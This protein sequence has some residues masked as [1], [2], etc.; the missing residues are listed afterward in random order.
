MIQRRGL[1]EHAVD[2]QQHLHRLLAGVDVDVRGALLDRFGDQRVHQLDHRRVLV[3]LVGQQ[4]RLGLVVRLGDGLDRLLDAGE[5][6]DQDVQVLDRGGR[7]AHATPG[8]HRDVVDRQHVGGV[9]HR[10]DHGAVLQKADRDRLVAADRLHVEQ[11]DSPHVDLVDR[12]VDVVQAIAF[13][14]HSGQLVVAKDALLDQDLAGRLALVPSELD[15]LLDALARGEAEVDDDVADQ[16]SRTKLRGGRERLGNYR[17]APILPAP[18]VLH[19]LGAGCGAVRSVRGD[20]IR[21]GWRAGVLH[22]S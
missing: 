7:S 10:E 2:A 3:G 18:V 8:Q 21:I 5:T 4:L 16:A 14:D 13:G 11:I 9:G 6:R 1:G 22:A 17:R 19:A 20:L 12:Q 15:G